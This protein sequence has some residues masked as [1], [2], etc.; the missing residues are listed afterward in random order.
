MVRLKAIVLWIYR[1][2]GLPT[3]FLAV[4]FACLLLIATR[5]N[6]SAAPAPSV[7]APAASTII[8][9]GHEVN[10]GPG[11]T[12]VWDSDSSKTG[13]SDTKTTNRSLSY[14][15]WSSAASI[16]GMLSENVD[17]KAMLTGPLGYALG[18]ST[19]GAGVLGKIFLGLHAHKHQSVGR[20]QERHAAKGLPS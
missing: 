18:G 10:V 2:P 6:R 20:K 5:A 1:N 14:V 13:A 9:D 19:L 15:D 7:A 17:W 3:C 8:I 4:V 11:L 16:V 12:F